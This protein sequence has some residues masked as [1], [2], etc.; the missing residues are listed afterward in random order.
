MEKALTFLKRMHEQGT[1]L[2][3]ELAELWEHYITIH[4]SLATYLN[5]VHSGLEELLELIEVALDTH[6]ES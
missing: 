3:T 4:P 1:E 6:T 5:H 2:E